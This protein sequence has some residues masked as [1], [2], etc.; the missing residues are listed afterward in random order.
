[1]AWGQ[2]SSSKPPT[3]LSPD[4]RNPHK[5]GREPRA[6]HRSKGAA[7]IDG[8]GGGIGHGTY[9]DL[10]TYLQGLPAHS[11]DGQ[12]DLSRTPMSLPTGVRLPHVR[13]GK[14]R[15]DHGPESPSPHEASD[16]LHSGVIRLDEHVRDPNVS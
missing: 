7:A 8:A 15:V 9:S 12:N 2:W 4:S 14:D 5:C 3:R 11:H 1:M 13:Q 6:L 10:V 16:S